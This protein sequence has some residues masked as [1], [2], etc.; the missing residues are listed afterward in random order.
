[1]RQITRKKSDNLTIKKTDGVFVTLRLFL[2]YTALSV[3]ALDNSADKPYYLNMVKFD[4]SDVTTLI[5]KKKL[6]TEVTFVMFAVLL[7]SAVISAVLTRNAIVEKSE[8]KNEVYA[9]CVTAVLL[10]C[11]IAV[12][13]FYVAPTD[14][15]LKL[16]VCKTIA[17]GLL[18]RGDMFRGGGVIEFTADYSGDILTLS[19]KNFTGAISID[20]ARLATA[21]GLG[22]AGAKI[23]LDLKPLKAVPA[24]YGAAGTKLWLFLN[25][26]YALHGKENGV[27]RVTVTD[28]MG[29][30]PY[31]LT[32]FDKSAPEKRGAKNYFIE[33][34]LVR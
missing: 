20:P 28:N 31:T 12:I 29:K 6:C 1:M 11:F 4:N 8:L 3:P 22:G 15:R 14:R 27:E 24:L 34:G 9:L 18:E 26:Y 10:V 2:Y 13:I 21:Q 19:R 16:C 25:A 32:V 5:K 7:I 23:E 33:K 17:E 30:T